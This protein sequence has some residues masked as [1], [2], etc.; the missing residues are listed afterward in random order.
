MLNSVSVANV[1]NPM[2]VTL[3]SITSIA[4]TLYSHMNFAL[5]RQKV[6]KSQITPQETLQGIKQDN[7]NLI[8][9]PSLIKEKK[10]IL[11][12]SPFH[13]YTN[14][15]QYNKLSP[16]KQ[17]QFKKAHQ[18]Y[19]NQV[20]IHMS[21]NKKQPSLCWMCSKPCY[22]KGASC[23]WIEKSTPVEGWKANPSL[24]NNNRT[25]NKDTE[26]INT[27]QVLDCPK[28]RFDTSRTCELTDIMSVLSFFNH[29][30]TRTIHRNTQKYVDRYNELFPFAPL[31]LYEE[32]YDE[33]EEADNDNEEDMNEDICREYSNSNV[34]YDTYDCS[35]L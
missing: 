30:S 25:N 24:I 10:D 16:E 6:V 9:V 11:N 29:V 22:K 20:I 27:Y 32:Y 18:Y 23:S 14:I 5:P 17:V 26:V 33:D 4:K 28:F 19:L 13:K 15:S 21:L 35:D 1:S 12:S 3:N 31:E 8:S 7:T 34:Y 2:N